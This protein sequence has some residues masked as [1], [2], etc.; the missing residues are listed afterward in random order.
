MRLLLLDNFDSF[1]FT[2]ADYL[3]QLRAEVL[4]RRNDVALAELQA[5]EFDGI[6]L[7]PGPG[8][9]AQAGVMPALIQACYQHVPMLGVCLGHQALGE[10]FGASVVRAARPMH[11]KVAEMWCDTT[12]PLF[13][14]LPA[15]QKVTR[16]HSLIVGAPLPPQVVPLAHTTGPNPELMALRHRSLPLFGVQFHPEALLTPHGL[17]ILGNWLR[18]CII[19]KTPQIDEKRDGTA[20]PASAWV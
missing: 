7:S 3:R 18:C 17:A 15:I 5:L 4:V 9:P 11:G 1:T 20:P 8:T 10:F 14:G 12:E 2:L 6:V 16:Y 19:A 13:A